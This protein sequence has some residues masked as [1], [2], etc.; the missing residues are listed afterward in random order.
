VLNPE[1]LRKQL[2]SMLTPGRYRHS[3][4]VQR[5]ASALA[6]L[7]G[8]DWFRAGVAGLVHDVCHCM[9]PEV[10]LKYLEEHG[11]LL[12]DFTLC[13]PPIWHAVTG[14][15]FLRE[16]LG[17]WDGEVLG[18][19]RCHTTGRA[20]MSDLEM[21]VFLAD[22]TSSDRHYPDTARLAQAS[23]RSLEDGMG[24]A[25]QST[26]TRLAQAGRPIVRPAL[27]AYNYYVFN[28]TT[29]L[30]RKPSDVF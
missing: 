21:V 12:D 17:V 25:M 28:E 7:H 14:S 8:A 18:A 5:R 23:D 29:L 10:Q 22:K 24:L 26:V 19:V 6:R 15:V 13:H 11:I 16:S 3:L 2:Q 1:R 27:D 9:P 30:R 20:A 4:C